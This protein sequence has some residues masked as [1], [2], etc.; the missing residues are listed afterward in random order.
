VIPAGRQHRQCLRNGRLDT[1]LLLL[2]LCGG[3]AT[4]AVAQEEIAPF[5]LSDVSADLTIGYTL[6]DREVGDFFTRSYIWE[7]RLDIRTTSYVYHPALLEMEIG[8]GPLLVQGGYN[9]DDGG[10]NSNDTLFNYDANFHFLE[11]KSYPF[12]LYMRRD[13]PEVATGTLGRFL[14]RTDE[15]GAF[16]TIRPPLTPVYVFWDAAHWTANG[17][18]FGSTVD[19]TVDRASLRT[20]LPYLEGQTVSLNL[21]LSDRESASGSPGLPIQESKIENFGAEL[22]GKNLFGSRRNVRLDQV[23][24]LQQQNTLTN[25]FTEIETLGYAGNLNWMHSKAANSYANY[26]YTDQERTET[27][28]KSQLFN[29]GTQYQF[30]NGVAIGGSGNFSSDEDPA[31]Q[32]DRTGGQLDARYATELPFGALGMSASVGLERTDQESDSDTAQVFDEPHELVG[33]APVRLDRDFVIV[34]TVVVTNVAQTQTFIEGLDYRLVTIGS[35][36]TIERIATGSIIDGETVLVSYEYATGGTAEYDTLL[37]SVAANLGFFGKV[38]VYVRWNDVTNDVRGGF[39]TTPLNDVNRFEVGGRAQFPFSAGWSL[40]GEYRYTDQDEDIAPF[41]GEH[42]EVFMQTASF[43]GTSARFSVISDKIDYEL[44]VEDVDRLQYV[45]AVSSRL[46]GATRLTYRL[47]SSKDDGGTIIREDLRQSL[48]FDWRYR[49]M[50]FSLR[51]EQADVAQGANRRD[52]IR[53]GAELRR[54]F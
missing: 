6:D 44:S 29:A 3:L 51:A 31:F 23:L 53:V 30:Q 2:F 15:F 50:T 38:N 54:S 52:Q 19:E 37:Q 48:Q 26:A 42:Y 21:N 34:D 33:V 32:R 9:S 43:W 27:W 45:V 22:S 8:F 5:K 20:T 17:S 46:P 24:R 10:N 12:T 36:T 14:T 7:E 4:R 39:P 35:T 1:L 11:R 18:G 25:T 40:G 13:H 41:V 47:V 49:R 16:G 28:T